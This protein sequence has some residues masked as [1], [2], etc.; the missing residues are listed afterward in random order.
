MSIR[1]KKA[2]GKGTE[3]QERV[4]GREDKR[5]V[6]GLETRDL[7][8]YR[9]DQRL[10]VETEVIIRKKNKTRNKKKKTKEQVESGTRLVY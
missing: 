4:K 2:A 1:S 7:Q 6:L 3:S 8:T 5:R 10:R 9:L